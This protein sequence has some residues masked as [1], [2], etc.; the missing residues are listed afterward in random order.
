MTPLIYMIT[1]TP[2]DKGSTITFLHCHLKPMIGL[3]RLTHLLKLQATL[4]YQP[5]K[6]LKEK[7]CW[8]ELWSKS[9]TYLNVFRRS[10]DNDRKRRASKINIARRALHILL[11]FSTSYLCELGFSMLTNIKYKREKRWSVLK[12]KMRVFISE[13]CPRIKEICRG[14][15]AQISQQHRIFK[16]QNA[17]FINVID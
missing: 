12:K 6:N 7:S 9:D 10:L 16:S 3:E 2:L 14:H 8:I 1:S 15:Q 11:Q 17:E 13:I 5:W 4:T